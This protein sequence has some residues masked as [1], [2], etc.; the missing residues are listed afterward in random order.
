MIDLRYRYNELQRRARYAWQG[1][2]DY[3]RLDRFDR[4]DGLSPGLGF[5]AVMVGRNDDYMPD[6]SRRLRATLEWNIRHLITEPIF[7]EWN[8]PPDRELLVHQLVREFPTLKVYVVPKS[9]HDEV[10]DNPRLPLMEYHAKNVG[11][12][13][14]ESDWVIATNADVALAPETISK[15]R[16]FGAPADDLAYTAERIDIHWREWRQAE[17][18]W[19]DCLRFKRLIPHSRYGTGDFLMASRAL[20]RRVGGY[21]E[22]LLRHRIG[23]DARGA[24][25]MIARGARLERIGRIL[26]LAHPT[27]CTEGVQPHHGEAAPLG[28]LPYDNGDDWGQGQRSLVRIGER[29]WQ[30]A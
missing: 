6:F 11:L 2:R 12:R 26:H 21:D 9:I 13:R 5:A 14:A 4:T 22:H 28:D 23:C 20:W 16:E 1:W 17:I 25:Q 15:C 24:A 29:I 27:S 19:A 8:P 3:S 7:V 18:G 30:L 10:C